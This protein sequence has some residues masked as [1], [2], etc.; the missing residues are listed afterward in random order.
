MRL[1]VSVPSLTLSE[2]TTQQKLVFE[3]EQGHIFGLI[4][5]AVQGQWQA[6]DMAVVRQAKADHDGNLV[7]RIE[8]VM[9]E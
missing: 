9:S 6:G 5:K 1:F 8:R 2:N 4:D 7:T 3:D